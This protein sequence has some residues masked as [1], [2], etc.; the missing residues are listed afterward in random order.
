LAHVVRRYNGVAGQAA[1]AEV[2]GVLG[3]RSA[4]DISAEDLKKLPL[5]RAA[6]SETLRLYPAAAGVWLKEDQARM[7]VL[8][9]DIHACE[10]W[11][12]RECHLRK[13]LL[14]FKGASAWLASLDAPTW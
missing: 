6:I 1:A 11:D 13:A 7:Y 5:L 12:T 2:Q 10:T 14:G 9:Y 4:A 8:L 3:D